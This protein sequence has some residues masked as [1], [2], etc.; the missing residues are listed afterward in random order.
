MW[1]GGLTAAGYGM[2]GKGR[3]G[4][5]NWYAHRFS[6]EMFI[7]TIPDG[8]ELDHLCRQRWCVNPYHLEAVTRRI[9]M[10]RGNHPLAIKWRMKNEHHLSTSN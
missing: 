7:G 9:N 4:E 2:F 3:R 10:L 5:G 1:L 8:L 6:Y